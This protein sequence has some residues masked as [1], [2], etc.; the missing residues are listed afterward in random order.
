VV[1]L[2]TVLHSG[3]LEDQKSLNL[4]LKKKLHSALTVRQV[5]HTHI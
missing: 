3:Q 4:H 2:C 1:I 5:S